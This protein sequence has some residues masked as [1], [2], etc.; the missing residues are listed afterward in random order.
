M[1][2]R[3]SLLTML[4]LNEAAV[5]KTLAFSVVHVS[6]ASPASPSVPLVG[7]PLTN[8][9]N[10]NLDKTRTSSKSTSALN[11]ITPNIS[12]DL[13]LNID[14]TNQNPRGVD[15]VSVCMG[16]LCK[17]QEESSELI[18][19]DLL[20]RNLP[21]VVEDAPCL[22]ACGMGAMVSIEY[23]DG[24]YDLVMGRLETF[25]AVG[26][27]IGSYDDSSNGDDDMRADTN[28]P[29]PNANAVSDAEVV[30]T[31]NVLVDKENVDK[32]VLAQSITSVP[33]DVIVQTQSLSKETSQATHIDISNSD[34]SD[35]SAAVRDDHG[36][37]KRMRD[38]AKTSNDEITNPWINMAL[39]LVNKAKDGI[40]K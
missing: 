23:Q 33:S 28:G 22:G 2:L 13:S 36:A 37:V 18:L 19:Q 16:E 8:G 3:T 11:S 24:G 6:S 1:K 29:D 39:Y 15:R 4:I 26:I 34:E 7:L 12:D 40:M 32:E 14:T 21:Y 25:Q 17:C 10:L 31:A 35:T 5:L 27:E 20:S 30:R 38:A 9:H